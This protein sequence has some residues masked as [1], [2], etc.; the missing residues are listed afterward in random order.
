[1]AMTWFLKPP[2]RRRGLFSML[3]L[4]IRRRLSP[5]CVLETLVGQP[6][7][8]RSV[9]DER[10]GIAE[11]DG[12]LPRRE[13]EALAF[14]CCVSEWLNRNPVRSP[15]GCCLGCDGNEQT[16]DPLLRFGTETSAHACL[17][18]RCWNQWRVGRRSQAVS[19]F[20]EM[21]IEERSPR[22]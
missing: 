9:F 18:R 6:T 2:R 19:A 12:G 15:P 21:G 1:M 8:G 14:A 20:A 22:P 3:C 10:A 16:H 5:C 13:A 7:I 17:D 4:A 11:F